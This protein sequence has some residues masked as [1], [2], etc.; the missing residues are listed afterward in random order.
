MQVS[1]LAIFITGSI[2]LSDI[3]EFNHFLDGRVTA[4]P[5]VLIVTGAIILLI[6]SL[7][8]YG[9]IR[10]SPSMMYAV[11]SIPTNLLS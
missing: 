8:C 11:I 7:G 2:V 5:I 1:G 10:E 3:N 4:S 9:A 6:A